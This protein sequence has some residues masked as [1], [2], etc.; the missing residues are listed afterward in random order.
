MENQWT[1]KTTITIVIIE[2]TLEEA[3]TALVELMDKN[4][5]KALKDLKD[6]WRK[7][8]KTN[9]NFDKQKRNNYV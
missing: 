2:K 1:F 9:W 4:K 7:N 6:N 5:E 8:F 3:K